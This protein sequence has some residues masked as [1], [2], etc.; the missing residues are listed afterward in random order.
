MKESK[1]LE[2]AWKDKIILDLG[3]DHY[4]KLF[5]TTNEGITISPYYSSNRKSLVNPETLFFPNEWNIISEIKCNKN[6]D[7]NEEIKRLYE[8]EIKNLIICNYEDQFIDNA[9][10]SQGNIY[11]KSERLEKNNSEFKLLIEPN[12][13]SKAPIDLSKFNQEKFRLNLSSEYFKNSGANIVQEIAF[14]LSVGIDYVNKFGKALFNKISFELIQGNNY[15]F[16]IAKIQALRI[17]WSIISKKYGNQID[18]CIITAKPSSKNKTTKNFNNNII[19]TTSECISGILGGCN[20]IKSIPYDIKFNDEN[21]FSQRITNN[22]LLILKHETS[23]ESVNNAIAGSYYIT[24]LIEKL[25][26]KSLDLIKKIENN[27]GYFN[28]QKNQIIFQE[29][30]MNDKKEKEQYE[31]GDKVLVGQNKFIND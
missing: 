25:A 24:Y 15:F 17:L 31:S 4:K 26:E 11:F 21:E 18:D 13:D 14:T 8:N 9:F 19:R 30:F 12:L 22:Q 2:K 6:T 29:I 7:L 16:E 1:N 10:L 28:D 23:I 5:S 3:R 20:F 27:G